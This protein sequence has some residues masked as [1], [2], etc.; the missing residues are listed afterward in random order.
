M[1]RS[2]IRP[3][4]LPRASLTRLLAAAVAAV[5][6]GLVLPPRAA[7]HAELV[8]SSPAAN[9]TL[10]EAPDAL[11]L[12]FSEAVDPGTVRV[13]LL[14]P[15]QRDIS[16]VGAPSVADSAVR[17][18][19]PEL[20]AGVYTVDYRV[21]SAVDG[22][23]TS[24]IF[25][26]LVDPTGTQPAPSVSSETDTPSTTPEATMARWVALAATLALA[27]T[28]VFWLG[29]ARPAMSAAGRPIVVPWPA[30]ALIGALAV[31]GLVA[32]LLLAARPIVEPGAGGW[33]P[34]DPAGPFGATQFAVAM[35]VALLGTLAATLLSAAF[36]ALGRRDAGA[37]LLTLGA[38]LIGMAGMSLAG[39]AAASGGPLFAA[40]DLLHLVAVAAWLG[41][42]VGAGLL[43]TL[44]RPLAGSALR[45]HSRVAL[46]A[47]PL[48]VL[49]GIASSPLL[50]GAEARDL[51]ASDYGNLL[52]AK[53]LLFGIAAG[54][55]AANFFLVRRR[56]PRAAVPILA[57]ELG[58]AA[59]AVAAAAGLVTGQP[60]A[61]RA[62]VLVTSAI[63]AAHLYGT[64]GDST[65]HAA[66]NLPAPGEQR[67]QVSVADVET[68]ASRDDVQRVFLV[69]APPPGSGLAP[70]RVQLD[71]GE[72]PG[73]WGTSGAYTPVVG[74]WTLDVVVRRAGE[75]DETASFALEVVLPLPP[76]R[77]PPPDSGVGVP[78]PVALLWAVLPPDPAAWLVSI[79]LLVAAGLLFGIGRVRAAGRPLAVVRAALVAAAVVVGIGAGSRALVAAANAPPPSAAA[80]ANPV[81]ADD[82]S[83]ARGERLYLA[84]CSSCH[85]ADGSG[86]GAAATGKLPPPGDLAD[87]VAELSDGALAYR[88]AV[89]SDG[90]RMPAFAATLSENDRWDLVNYLRSRFAP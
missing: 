61:N 43:L 22:H 48:V 71:P 67:Y 33:F 35:R 26:F 76:Q 82:A 77:V 73:L 8:S 28:L 23:V 21:T 2:A 4:T 42:L 13:R 38:V 36:G 53:V 27:G 37:L 9:A 58:V 55:G 6:L 50:L 83:V 56:T 86:D 32:Y 34:L 3:A 25:A 68:G 85:G 88:I 51:V 64:A 49:S 14:D 45:R 63:G 72:E 47:A 52:L 39:H 70:E 17:V 79:G 60:A 31:S 66:V 57:A 29:S 5:L 24:G 84:N 54:L 74:D 75:R 89:G 59:L 80:Q 62:P 46:V 20:D 78:L 69:F 87:R 30:L 7:A 15:Q 10:P 16:G 65:V 90:T 44:A 81:R 41:S 18:S 12:T 19:L 11:E 40:F 1:R